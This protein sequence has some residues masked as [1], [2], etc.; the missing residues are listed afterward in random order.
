MRLPSVMGRA[1]RYLLLRLSVARG[2]ETA[3]RS[4]NP[5]TTYA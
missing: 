2:A 4:A 3:L 5:L 1:A